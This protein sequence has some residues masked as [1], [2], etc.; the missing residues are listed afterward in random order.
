[1]LWS[2]IWMF[3]EP[4]TKSLTPPLTTA[5]PNF[6]SHCMPTVPCSLIDTNKLLPN[7]IKL[8]DG[9][10]HDLRRLHSSN[11]E[12]FRSSDPQRRV[13]P[14]AQIIQT[15]QQRL[16]NAARSANLRR[17]IEQ[18][19]CKTWLSLIEEAKIALLKRRLFETRREE[20]WEG[21]LRCCQVLLPTRLAAT[22]TV[23]RKWCN[24]PR[25]AVRLKVE[26]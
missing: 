25:W 15:P 13:C 6:E 22:C 8:T 1:M 20:K 5:L 3:R 19:Y 10:S 16:K 24:R 23:C 11:P 17:G 7:L 26:I 4:S 18:R 21:G 9:W 12:I 14:H 2:L